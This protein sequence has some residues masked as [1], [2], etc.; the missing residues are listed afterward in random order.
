[1]KKS[2]TFYQFLAK[3]KHSFFAPPREGDFD[4]AAVSAVM[5][6]DI[7]L[8]G[9]WALVNST[10]DDVV[11][12]AALRAHELTIRNFGR[13][14]HLYTPMYLSNFCDNECVYCGFKKG[15]TIQR[16]TLTM[17]EVRRESEYIYSKGFRNILI[18][19]GGARGAAPID[20]IKSCVK[21]LRERFSSISIEVYELTTDEYRELID[22]G[23]DGLVIYQEVYDED[24][25]RKVH[26]SGAKQ[27]YEFRLSAPERALSA[28]MRTV[29]IGALLG[30][31]EWKSEGFFTALH[32]SYLEKMF[33]SA[34]ISISVPRIR[35]QVSSFKPYSEVSDKDLVRIVTS[36]RVFLPRVGITLSTRERAYLRDILLSVGVTRMSAG[37]TTCVGGHTVKKEECRAEQFEISDIRDLN[38]IKDMLRNKG[39]Q[40]VLKD[41]T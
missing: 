26:L 39:Y 14:I 18:L 31:G 10:S 8:G 5:S 1:M 17:D 24:I 16:K 30:L 35:P 2:E 15:N 27:N 9:F 40:P 28:G 12:K 25:Y 23:V 22:E 19:T 32:A 34:E 29:S 38:E 3:H 13:V 11:E 41:W 7:D 20:Y 36:L 33:P 21:I 4:G 6:E 37:S